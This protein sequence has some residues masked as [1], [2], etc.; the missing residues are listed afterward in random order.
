MAKS[1]QKN[2]L[3]FIITKLK[4]SVGEIKVIE[5]ANGTCFGGVHEINIEK[6]TLTIIN[7]TGLEKIKLAEKN[8]ASTNSV[9]SDS[10]CIE[11]ISLE[12]IV[13]IK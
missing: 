6:G 1:K 7:E 11:I 10:N 2:N 5:H 9:Y 8:N 3:D 13:S 12:N 4:K